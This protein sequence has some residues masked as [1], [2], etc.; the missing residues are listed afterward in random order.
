MRKNTIQAN[1][2]FCQWELIMDCNMECESCNARKKLIAGFKHPKVEMVLSGIDDLIYAG[3]KNLEFIGGEPLLYENL[4]VV[5][6]YLNQRKEIK[7]FAVLTNGIARDALLKI[8]PELSLKKGGLVVSI[9]YTPEK[10]EEL[11]KT[12][13]DKDMVK[14]SIAGWRVLEEFSDHCWVRV[15]CTVN[16]INCSSLAEIALRIIKMGGFFSLCPLIYK[17]V[18]YNSG[19]EFTFRSSSVG[20][21]PLE[22]YKKTIEKS[23]ME[24]RELKRRYPRQ[25]I[26]SEDYFKMVIESCKNPSKLYSANCSGLGLPYLRVSSEIGKSLRDGKVAF[27]LR[28]C[29]DIKGSNIS[30]IVTSDLRKLNV[31]KKL[32][33][34]YQRDPEVR[35]CCEREGCVWSVT[36]LLAS[37]ALL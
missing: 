10:C 14:K 36:H 11:L 6:R 32:P 4:P 18:G 34:I 13:I 9:N 15:N 31:R 30:K 16:T 26:P 8:K 29:S 28:A 7:R 37:K 5:L 2:P 20:L 21:A 33:L 35:K 27:Q 3:V 24:L 25:I 1:F 22:K 17:R 12:G 23:I 19:L